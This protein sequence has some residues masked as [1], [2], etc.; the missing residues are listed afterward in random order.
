MSW[1][2]ID[3]EQKTCLTCQHFRGCP[4]RLQNVGRTLQ[5]QFDAQMGVCGIFNNFP[6]HINE[7]A[8]MVSYCHYTRWRELP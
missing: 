3:L 6:K 4:R 8:G 2:T 5:L 1:F 7:K